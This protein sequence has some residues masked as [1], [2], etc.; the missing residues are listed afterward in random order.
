MPVELIPAFLFY[1]LVGSITPGPA[2]LC[3]LASALNFGKK[4]ALVQWR[5]L[6]T[7]FTIVSLCAVFVTYFVGAAMGTYVKY[8]SYVGAAYILWLA[9][10]IW[11]SGDPSEVNARERCNFFTGLLVQLTNVK[12]MIYC[13]TALSAYVL[14]YKQD[15]L[16]LLIVGLLLPFTGP[17]ANLVWLFSGV[18]LQ[19]FFF[20]YRRPLNAVMALSLVFCAYSMIIR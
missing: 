8:L 2:N 11:K 14:P 4:Q 7:G 3:S 1:C 10:H 18:A 20:R 15:F 17:V 16:S 19:K 5:G 9:W 12:I 6:F 13:L